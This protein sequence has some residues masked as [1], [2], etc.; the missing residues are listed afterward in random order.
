MFSVDPESI[1]FWPGEVDA[2]PKTALIE[3]SFAYYEWEFGSW[4][5]IS[6]VDMR[7]NRITGNSELIRAR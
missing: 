2:L 4:E 3:S 1:R 7:S 6:A 5:V